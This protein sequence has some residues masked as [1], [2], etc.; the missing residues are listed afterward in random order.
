MQTGVSNQLRRPNAGG[1]RGNLTTG[2]SPQVQTYARGFIY[3]SL[4]QQEELLILVHK[5]PQGSQSGDISPNRKYRRKRPGLVHQQ[6]LP[7]LTHQTRR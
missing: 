7:G 4:P 3:R 1:R 2:L 5:R 6:P